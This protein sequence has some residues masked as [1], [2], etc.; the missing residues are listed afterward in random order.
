MT[1]I[2]RKKKEIQNSNSKRLKN[3]QNKNAIPFCSDENQSSLC[4]PQC[5]MHFFRL[6]AKCLSA[7]PS[8]GWGVSGPG[9]LSGSP[10]HPHPQ[11]AGRPRTCRGLPRLVRNMLGHHVL[12]RLLLRP[13]L[14]PSSRAAQHGRWT[15][16]CPA[17][18]RLGS[19]S[20]LPSSRPS[21]SASLRLTPTDLSSS[22][23]TLSSVIA[24]LL[25]SPSSQLFISVTVLLSCTVFREFFVFSTSSPTHCICPALPCPVGTLTGSSDTCAPRHCRLLSLPVGV[26]ILNTV[27]WGMLTRCFHKK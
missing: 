26:D 4:V 16:A 15:P 6:P 14:P 24:T 8:A 12:Q 2:K 3:F 11:S 13:I 25:L 5:V 21:P 23:C 19:G 17:H 22:S 10:P 9:C 18:P 7:I 1:T 20:G 27:T